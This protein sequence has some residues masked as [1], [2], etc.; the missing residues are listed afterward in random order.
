[1][2]A[3]ANT[4][5]KSTPG[6]YALILQTL[7]YQTIPVGRWGSLNIRPGYYVYVGSARGPGGVKAR[8]SRHCRL[9]K[10]K[11]WHIDYLREYASLREIWYDYSPEPLEHRWAQAFAR[12]PAA[13]AIKGFGSSDCQCEAHLFFLL[14][15][16]DLTAFSQAVGFKVCT[17]VYE[18]D[19]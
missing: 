4:A 1:M 7:S 5:L 13:T 18:S 6:T 12:M 16:P 2:P 10:T 11:H 19:S 9:N 17:N 8:T 14:G 3:L 15:L